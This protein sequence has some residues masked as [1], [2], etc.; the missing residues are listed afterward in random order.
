MAIT[1]VVEK[2]TGQS[3]SFNADQGTELLR[4]FSV[5]T[6]GNDNNAAS[7]TLA[8]GIP[9]IGDRFS[10][11]GRT[12]RG[13]QCYS[14]S[15]NQLEGGVWDVVCRYEVIGLRFPSRILNGQEPAYTRLLEKPIQVI[16]G[17]SSL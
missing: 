2:P 1:R 17:S 5:T 4:F 10:S 15:P 14:I 3:G 12:V 7:V 8:P 11:I 16:W 9:R 6:T 13:S